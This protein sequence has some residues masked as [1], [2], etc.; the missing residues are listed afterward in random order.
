MISFKK[1]MEV[2]DAPNRT[3]WEDSQTMNSIDGLEMSEYGY[4][5]D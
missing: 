4:S 5:Q 3:K 1:E 2:D